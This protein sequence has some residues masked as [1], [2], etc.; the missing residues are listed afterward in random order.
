[1]FV[2]VL[3]SAAHSACGC[4]QS[5]SQYLSCRWNALTC[6]KRLRDEQQF[7]PSV[8]DS[9]SDKR[10]EPKNIYTLLAFSIYWQL[11]MD[12]ANETHKV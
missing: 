6:L 12:T 7:V 4:W 10:A 8:K 3:E 1:M 2:V 5:A 11:M 9:N